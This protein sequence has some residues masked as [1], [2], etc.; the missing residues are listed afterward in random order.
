MLLALNLLKAKAASARRGRPAP[1]YI[2]AGWLDDGALL[3]ASPEGTVRQLGEAPPSSPLVVSSGTLWSSA[4]LSGDACLLACATRGAELRLLDLPSGRLLHAHAAVED[5]AAGERGLERLHPAHAITSLTAWHEG[6]SSGRRAMA[7]AG[8]SNGSVVVVSPELREDALDALKQVLPARELG[9]PAAVV[10]LAIAARG[11]WLVSVEATGRAFLWELRWPATSSPR[12]VLRDG[13]SLS[14]SASVL[15]VAHPGGHQAALVDCSSGDVLALSLRAAAVVRCVRGASEWGGGLHGASMRGTSVRSACFDA[16]GLLL[17]CAG[18]D[19][20]VVRDW[21]T[22]RVLT[23]TASGRHASPIL[24]ATVRGGTL[25][26]AA[27]DGVV[28]VWRLPRA[29]AAALGERAA[30]IV[31]GVV[32]ASSRSLTDEAAGGQEGVEVH[33]VLSMDTVP[34]DTQATLE[35]TTRAA[36]A[37]TPRE[38]PPPILLQLPPPPP[39]DTSAPAE[40]VSKESPRQLKS[41]PTPVPIA[42]SA[43][44]ASGTPEWSAVA[45][46]LDGLQSEQQAPSPALDEESGAL[47][48]TAAAALLELDQPAFSTPSAALEASAAPPVHPPS[49]APSPPTPAP[50]VLILPSPTSTATEGSVS[51]DLSA[52]SRG[53]RPGRWWGELAME[54]AV[55]GPSPLEAA[56]LPASH[57]GGS[58]SPAGVPQDDAASLM[59]ASGGLSWAAFALLASTTMMSAGVS[60]AGVSSAASRRRQRRR[61]QAQQHQHAATDRL[62]PAGS[63]SGEL[64]HSVVPASPPA[65]TGL[66]AAGGE[67]LA[68]LSALDSDTHPGAA[69]ILLQLESAVAA[70]VVLLAGRTDS[71]EAAAVRAAMQN[72]REALDAALAGSQGAPLPPPCAPAQWA[73]SPAE[74]E[75]LPAHPPAYLEAAREQ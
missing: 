45:A 11:R 44:S 6:R 43:G 40:L 25:L 22:G 56:M 16:T 67:S 33:S 13:G 28:L 18:D 59:W 34:A 37:D 58:A 19:A 50:T 47:E 17:L 3:A 32:A 8:L 15:A 12:E 10:A 70:A 36:P 60:S 53:G 23:R 64:A 73:G 66:Q 63:G 75:G 54:A 27:Q 38:T 69:H 68:P 24:A 61:R 71:S 46:Y 7:A 62:E 39:I 20:V 48:R 55:A 26:T 31:A 35:S 4:C 21:Y 30:E 57:A 42:Q 41:P 72:A 14:L 74:E 5:D 9:S 51:F 29:V 52:T 49:V 1:S 2:A 65:A